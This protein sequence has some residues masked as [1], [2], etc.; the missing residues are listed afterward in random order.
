VVIRC[1]WQP[2]AEVLAEPNAIDMIRDYWEE[3]SPEKDSVP[4][5][6]DWGLLKR[7]ECEGVYK[8]WTARVDGT[9]AGFISFFIQPHHNYKSTLMGFDAGHF[10]SPAYRN[11]P[12]RV[13]FKMWRTAEAGLRAIG[14]AQVMI[15]DNAAR[16]LLPFFLGMGYTPRSV[17]YWKSL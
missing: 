2:L 14:V 16:P 4:L 3:L 7:L 6:P 15:H 9:L 5:D 10:L 13:G 17:I 1:S 12:G 11:S 8:I